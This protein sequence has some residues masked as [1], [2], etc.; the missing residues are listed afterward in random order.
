MGM[1]YDRTDPPQERER[2]IDSFR[3]AIR[4][5]PDYGE[6]YTHLAH[7]L[8]E[9]RDLAE[10]ESVLKTADRLDANDPVLYYV[11]GLYFRVIGQPQDAIIQFHKSIEMYPNLREPHYELGL[12]LHQTGDL[13]GAASEFRKSLELVP[14]DEPSYINLSQVLR[15]QGKI[16]EA[17]ALL[18]KFWK[19]RENGDADARASAFSEKGIELGERGDLKGAIANLQAAVD[20][21]P[22]HSETHRNLA[23]ALFLDGQIREAGLQNEETTRL[24]PDD[25]QAHYGL[26][27]IYAEQNRVA[28]SIREFETAARLNPRYAEAHYMLSRLYGLTNQPEKAKAALARAQ[29]IDPHIVGRME[30]DK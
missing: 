21:Q 10:A 5:K 9:R 1:V 15:Q 27:H 12:I 3:I 2:A 29:A 8:L 4:L 25:P 30:A 14:D 13:N 22:R 17:D 24:N 6:A 26:G 11:K 23:M 19:L 7:M 20:L 16:H 28:D 18:Q